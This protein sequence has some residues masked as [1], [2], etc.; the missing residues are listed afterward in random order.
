MDITHVGEIQGNVPFL[1][2]SS[3]PVTVTYGRKG[4][5]KAQQMPKRPHISLQ[6]HSN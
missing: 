2:K 6:V 3:F 5:K 4:S 1:G